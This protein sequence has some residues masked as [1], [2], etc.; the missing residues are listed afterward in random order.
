MGWNVEGDAHFKHGPSPVVGWAMSRA[1]TIATAGTM[2]TEDAPIN[3]KFLCQHGKNHP[4]RQC[5]TGL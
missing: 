5:G 3:F 1:V 2:S 4:H